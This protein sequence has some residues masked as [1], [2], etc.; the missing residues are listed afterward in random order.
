MTIK[1]IKLYN[2]N[3]AKKQWPNNEPMV[4]HYTA[5]LKVIQGEN[6]QESISSKLVC[7]TYK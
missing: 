7:I 5:I 6:R 1:P 4:A 2:K 3:T